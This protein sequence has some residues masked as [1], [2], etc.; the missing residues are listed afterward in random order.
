MNDKVYELRWADICRALW[1]AG[2][3]KDFSKGEC[4]RVNG[5]LKQQIENHRV[6]QIERGRYRVIL[7]SAEGDP[8]AIDVA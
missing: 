7:P 6:E 5:L 2:L 1:A 3:M 4:L 8:D